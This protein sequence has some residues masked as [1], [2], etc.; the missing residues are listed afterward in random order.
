MAHN[1]RTPQDHQSGQWIGLGLI[2]G[3]GLGVVVGIFTD[4]LAIGAALGLI[5]GIVL[6]LLS[7]R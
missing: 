7:R 5:A 6:T 2:L 4:A 3:A 1:P